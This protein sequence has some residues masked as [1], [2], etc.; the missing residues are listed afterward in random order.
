MVIEAVITVI[1][2]IRPV[3]AG[4]EVC[5]QGLAAMVAAVAMTVV[6]VGRQW[7]AGVVVGVAV[8]M[9]TVVYKYYMIA[10]P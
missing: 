3:R 8:M 7:A 1:A 10:L 4:G 6:S 2:R 5:A 9:L